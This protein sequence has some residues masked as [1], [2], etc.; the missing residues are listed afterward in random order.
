MLNYVSIACGGCHLGSTSTI[1]I[2]TLHRL[3]NGSS[4]TVEVQSSLK[5]NLTY[6]GP[7]MIPEPKFDL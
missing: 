1:K 7:H 3:V 2:Q 5:L 6:N 4:C